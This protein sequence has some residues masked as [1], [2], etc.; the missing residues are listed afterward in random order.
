MYR[1]E[2]TS[3]F[4]RVTPERIANEPPMKRQRR[5]RRSATRRFEHLEK[6]RLG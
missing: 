5:P 4:S 3:G 1:R 6:L 2:N